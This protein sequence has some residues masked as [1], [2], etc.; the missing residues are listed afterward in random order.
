MSQGL[1]RSEIPSFL[2]QDFPEYTWS[3]R[4]LDR[5]MRHFNIYYTDHGMA[6]EQVVVAVKQE[7]AGPGKHLGIRAM[8]TKLRQKHGI[9]VPRDLAHAAMTD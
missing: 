3:V 2:E 5:R 9:K 1:Q 4:T 7:L 6:V 8:N